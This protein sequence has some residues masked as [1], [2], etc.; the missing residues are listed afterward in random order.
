MVIAA[1]LAVVFTFNGI[2]CLVSRI[3]VPDSVA[4]QLVE[5]NAVGYFSSIIV[6]ILCCMIFSAYE[7]IRRRLED[8]T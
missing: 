2:I 6:I 5:L 3:F 8:R 1:V 7:W 4:A